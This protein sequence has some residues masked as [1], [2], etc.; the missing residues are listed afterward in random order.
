MTEQPIATGLAPRLERYLDG[1]TAK[2]GALG[3]PQVRLLGPGIDVA[4]GDQELPFHA[5]S[6]GKLFTGV[7]VLQLVSEGELQLDAPIDEI[8][9]ASRLKGLLASGVAAPTV[10]QLLQHVGGVA[11][12]YESDLGRRNGIVH[13]L[14]A[15]PHQVWTPD[16][17]LDFTRDHKRPI[18]EP[19]RR[20]RYSDTGFVLLGKAIDAVSGMR[21][22]ETVAARI[23]K[24]LELRR[25]FL[26]RLTEPLEGEARIAACYNGRHDLSQTNALSCGWAGGG[27]ASTPAD[28]V[29]FSR[30]L[31]GGEL[32][33]RSEYAVMTDIRNRVRAG[34]H[35]GAAMMELRFD[36]FSPMLRGYPRP[37]GHLGSLG[38][39]LFHDRERGTHLAMNFHSRREISRSIRAA[40]AIEGAFRRSV[41]AA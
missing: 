40:I 12:Y 22:H 36:G 29:R 28:L 1:L 32:L 3:A 2:R 19:G 7:V 15:D 35:Y 14:A 24:P 21:Y 30:A 37:V 33:A 9:P 41:K 39:Y 20:F 27:V 23:I 31:H 5:A 25:T 38:T 10:L 26:P 34:I 11:D 18:A 4:Y 13:E 16:A 6:V 8:L 17:L